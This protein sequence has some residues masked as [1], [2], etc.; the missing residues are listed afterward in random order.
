[1]AALELD[2]NESAREAVLRDIWNAMQI[3]WLKHDE[4]GAVDILG[5]YID[6]SLA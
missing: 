2:G 4:L 6:E 1:M 3:S 5:N